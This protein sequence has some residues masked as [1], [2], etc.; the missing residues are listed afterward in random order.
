[1]DDLCLRYV[2]PDINNN[3]VLDVVEGFRDIYLDFHNWFQPRVG[4]SPVSFA[5]LENVFLPT[6][7]EFT[8]VNTGVT[9]EISKDSYYSQSYT[10]NLLYERFQFPIETIQPP[11]GEYNVRED[12][13]IS[14]VSWK[15]MKKSGSLWVEATSTEIELIVSE[16]GG[17]VSTYIDGNNMTSN[18]KISFTLPRDVSGTIP[19]S[20]A[21]LENLTTSEAEAMTTR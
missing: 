9:F 21:L 8:Y 18:K 14:G 16:S 12:D 17:F 7:A 20:D 2:N 10:E 19:R 15:W 13:T 5:D 4:G 11:A 1:M 6:N 3:G